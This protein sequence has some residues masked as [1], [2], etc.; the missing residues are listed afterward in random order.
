VNFLRSL[1]LSVLMVALVLLVS[2]AQL[3]HEQLGIHPY[4][5]HC[6]LCRFSGDAS[7]M[8]L[9]VLAPPL[10]IPVVPL[11]GPVAVLSLCSAPCPC[12]S[13]RD[14]PVIATI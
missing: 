6:D 2:G 10:V 9:P 3:L 13:A 8:L 4:G 5:E 14:P 11:P 7:A 12:P 1:R